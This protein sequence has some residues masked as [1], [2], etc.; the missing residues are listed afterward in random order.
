MIYWYVCNMIVINI[1]SK[2][3]ICR[4]LNFILGNLMNSNMPSDIDLH[5]WE[6]RIQT[7][8]SQEFWESLKKFLPP[9][10]ITNLFKIHYNLLR[11]TYSK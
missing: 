8:E 6:S 3:N 2:T 7:K 4:T 1:I 9:I 10:S 5:A 11:P